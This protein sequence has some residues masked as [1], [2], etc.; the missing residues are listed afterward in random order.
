M[1]PAV[2][3]VVPTRN[4]AAFL[5]EALASAFAQSCPDFELLV[6]DDASS[7]ETLAVA[8][9]FA[10]ERLVIHVTDRPRGLPGNWNR[11]LELARGRHVKFLFQDDVLGPHALAC[12]V[13]AL[14]RPGGPALAFGR[15]EIR[16]EAPGAPLLGELYRAHL[17]RF[18]ATTGALA[19]GLDLVGAWARG[20]RPLSTNVVGEPSFVLVRRDAAL[21]AGGFDAGLRQLAD[22]D[23][24]L[25]LARDAPLAFVDRSLGTFRV[26]AR[27]ASLRHAAVAHRRHFEHA[28]LLGNVRR[29]YGGRL[30]MGLRARLA[31][32]QAKALGNGA[33]EAGVALLR[34]RGNL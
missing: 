7:D 8:R 2:S 28:R 13:E 9:S 33:A 10:D 26:H 32:A 5:R 4:G 18:Y 15:R 14:E 23:L 34:P 22:W 16:H 27:G 19:S 20:E 1:A 29:W 12:L 30:P 24:W 25:K 3:V 17:D 31:L 6:V 11:G 21:A